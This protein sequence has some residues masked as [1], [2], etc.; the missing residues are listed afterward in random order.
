M[1]LLAGGSGITSCLPVLEELVHLASAGRCATRI[2][3]LVWT[4][5]A[6]D[7]LDWCRDVLSELIRFARDKTELKV[8]VS[9]HG[10]LA[11]LGLSFVECRGFWLTERLARL[12][13]TMNQ[14][15]A[16]ALPAP[17]AS[18][19]PHSTLTR[20]RPDLSAIMDAHLAG[21]AKRADQCGRAR[22]GA[23]GV[24]VCGP[25]GMVRS[26]RETVARVSW[27]KSTVA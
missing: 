3:T 9:L 25:P 5:R 16:M 13:V 4:V 22:G 8:R 23:L 12:K 24:G 10:E 18:P 19:I 11:G 2:V 1:I 20:T 14:L 21:L 6:L 27:S 15:A 7:N 17:L 26:A